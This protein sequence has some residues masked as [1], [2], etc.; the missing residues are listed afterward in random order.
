MDNEITGSEVELREEH[1]QALRGH[2]VR[3]LK[4]GHAKLAAAMFAGAQEE[5]ITGKLKEAIEAVIEVSNDA[6]AWVERYTVYDEEKPTGTPK[7]GKKRPRIDITI[8]R[9]WK[10]RE[11]HPRFRF[12]AKR[13]K[14]DKRIGPY[15]G[16]EGIGCFLRGVYPLTHGEAG[17]IGYVQAGTLEEWKEHLGRYAIKRAKRLRILPGGDW[18]DYHCCLPHSSFSQHKHPDFPTLNVIHLLLSFC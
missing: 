14:A 4:M 3:L 13:L 5:D 6:P 17:M 10:L 9:R 12:E 8:K 1:R 16:K 11:S 15:F 18:K 7:L 2:A